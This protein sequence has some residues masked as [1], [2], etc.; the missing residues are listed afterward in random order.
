MPDL[1]IPQETKTIIIGVTGHRDLLNDDWNVFFEGSSVVVDETSRLYSSVL[2]KLSELNETHKDRGL[3]LLTGMAEGADLLVIYVA[4]KLNIPFIAVLAYSED[5]Y[6]KNFSHE[7]QRA[8]FNHLLPCAQEIVTC[9]PAEQAD[10]YRQVGITIASYA[11]ELIALWN[12]V[13]TGL[14]GGTWEVVRM[15]RTGRDDRGQALPMF[16]SGKESLFRL[17]HLLTP[18]QHNPYPILRLFNFTSLQALLP[19]GTDYSWT[20]L[21]EK[22]PDKPTAFSLKRYRVLYARYRSEINTYAIPFILFFFTVLFGTLGIL[23]YQDYNNQHRNEPHA[24]YITKDFHELSGLDAFYK[25]L[26][27]ETLIT[28]AFDYEASHVSTLYWIG[29]YLGMVFFLY[30]GFGVARKLLGKRGSRLVVLLGHNRRLLKKNGSILLMLI[31]GTTF[32]YISG[33]VPPVSDW[34]FISLL[35]IIGLYTY[36][37]IRWEVYSKKTYNL[38]LGL[39]DRSTHTLS[40]LRN[41]HERV[42]VLEADN[43]NAPHQEAHQAHGHGHGA[44]HE[45]ES[46]S[47]YVK[48]R[49]ANRGNLTE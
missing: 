7:P 43:H 20:V 19:L 3:L 42:V 40:D 14:P 2:A 12:G 35:S 8:L 31:A 4:Q 46:H 28:P 23:N 38:L 32:L 36:V 41:K 11:D 47:R 22:R 45:P 15:A 49:A 21:A 44:A 37:L 1:S 27:L 13:D 48:K 26:H 25:A 30:A 16:R 9:A 29:K 33:L 18:R 10:S 17:H 5:V 34:I 24:H 39:N 6:A